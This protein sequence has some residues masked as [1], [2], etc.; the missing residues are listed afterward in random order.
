[1]ISVLLIDDNGPFRKSLRAILERADDIQIVAT[2]SNGVDGVE[3]TISYH[4]ELAVMDISMPLRD[5]LEA[6]EDIRECCRLTSVII[7]SGFDNPEY[8]RR[9]LDVGAKGY[10]LK[11]TAGEDILDAI[12]AVQGGNHYFSKQIAEIAENYLAQRGKA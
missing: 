11:D 12:H 4:P 2:A 10:V 3:K 5:G 7:L 6:T 9:A 1:M 8:I